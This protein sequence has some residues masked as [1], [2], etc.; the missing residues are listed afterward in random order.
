MSNFLQRTIFGAVYVGLVIAAL[1]LNTYLFY[2]VMFTF[3][4]LSLYE[5]YQLIFTSSNIEYR[6]LGFFIAI[7]CFIAQ[8][9]DV[10]SFVWLFISGLLFSAVAAFF[11]RLSPISRRTAKLWVMGML[12]IVLPLCVLTHYHQERYYTP[13]LGNKPD[14]LVLAT[15]ILIWVNDTGAYLTG[16]WLGKHPLAPKIS[17]KKTWEGFIGGALITLG[18]AY[19]FVENNWFNIKLGPMLALAAVFSVFGP[20]GDLFESS[21]KRKAGVKDSGN[22]IPGHG[23]I[24]DRLDGLLMA[25]L[26]TTVIALLYLIASV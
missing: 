18:V 7:A 13:A 21:L 2:A 12:Y 25:T 9:L 11:I 4:V 3:M 19:L 16:R 6:V 20:V 23:G 10:K 22:I 5:Y 24:L 26:A 17:P 14:L 1:F 8:I 15:F